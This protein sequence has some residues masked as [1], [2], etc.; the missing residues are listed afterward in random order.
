MT[1]DFCLLIL[2]LPLIFR[3]IMPLARKIQFTLLYSL[4]IICIVLS[5]VR[6]PINRAS[7][8]L[9][10]SRTL[11]S[12]LEVLASCIVANAPALHGIWRDWR[13][14]RFVDLESARRTAVG[15][16]TVG[17]SRGGTVDGPMVGSAFL[18]RR[19][20]HSGIE[21]EDDENEGRMDEVELEFRAVSLKQ[22]PFVSRS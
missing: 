1:T 5:A 14:R 21:E 22:S 16:S 13:T 7:R 11:F 3:S 17:R 8:S 18:K 10:T 20:S 12:S 6:V 15:G 2:P 19:R 9:Q 4:G